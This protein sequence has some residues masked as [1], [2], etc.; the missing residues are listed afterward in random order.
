MSVIWESISQCIIHAAGILFLRD[1]PERFIE[2]NL[3]QFV[4][5]IFKQYVMPSGVSKCFEVGD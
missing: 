3:E 1:N 2:S 4:G 5:S